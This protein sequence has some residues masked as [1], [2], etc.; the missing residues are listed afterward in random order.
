MRHEIGSI[1]A[2]ERQQGR[3]LPLCPSLLLHRWQPEAWV[4]LR[5]S[6]PALDL[7]GF[8]FERLPVGT[9]AGHFANKKGTG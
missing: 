4:M 7:A 6:M 8:D 3:A 1:S 9:G 5:G 2:N